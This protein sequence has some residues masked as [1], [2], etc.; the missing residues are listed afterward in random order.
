[1]GLGAIL[2]KMKTVLLLVAAVTSAAQTPAPAGDVTGV[3]NFSHIVAN[4]ER[5]VE[6][7]R[8]VLGLELTAQPRPFDPN[9]P[10]LRIGNTIGAQSRIAV[11][12]VA[13]SAIGMELIDYT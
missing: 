3:G 2:T 9:P 11:L 8:D 5:S 10:I 7:Y 6:F 12:R 1:M 4:L 13:G